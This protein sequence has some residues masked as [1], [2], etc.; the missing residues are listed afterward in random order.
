MN[1]ID[2]LK[3]PAF[4]FAW[5]GK[6]D[7]DGKTF[8]AVSHVQSGFTKLELASLMIGAAMAERGNTSRAAALESVGFAQDI[9]E[10][11]NK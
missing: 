4:P 10:Y 6:E 8:S 9:L 11:C 5:E 7:K 3:M 1:I 2:N